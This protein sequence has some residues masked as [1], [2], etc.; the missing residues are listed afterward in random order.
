M[1]TWV[2][3]VYGEAERPFSRVARVPAVCAVRSPE[4]RSL[5]RVFQFN[6]ERQVLR[7]RLVLCAAS[8]ELAYTVFGRARQRMRVQIR[9]PPVLRR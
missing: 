9:G 7:T 2:V 1:R 8:S 3:A 6:H 4:C 5:S